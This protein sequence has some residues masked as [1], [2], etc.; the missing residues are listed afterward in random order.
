MALVSGSGS[1]SNPSPAMF[2]LFSLLSIIEE[3]VESLGDKELALVANLFTQF[4]QQSP[5]PMTWRVEG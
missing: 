5:E 2:A 3:Q 4:P 1:S